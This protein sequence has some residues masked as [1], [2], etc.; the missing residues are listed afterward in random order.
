M[1]EV[2]P[3]WAPV[4]HQSP[5]ITAFI[6]GQRE[7]VTKNLLSPEKDREFSLISYSH[8]QTKLDLGKKLFNFFLINQNGIILIPSFLGSAV[9]LNPLPHPLSGAGGWE[10]G[11]W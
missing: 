10:M 8:G 1:C 3:S 2:V 4:A 5:S 9:L 11:L 7:N 6:R